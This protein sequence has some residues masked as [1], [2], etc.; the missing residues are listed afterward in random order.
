MNELA[1]KPGL[2]VVSLY[3]QVHTLAQVEARVEQSKILYPIALDGFWEFGYE[4][5][6]LPRTWIVGVDGK[7]IWA[8]RAGYKETLDKEL[9]KVKYPGLGKAEVHKSLE[10]AAKAFVEGR[11][12]EAHKLAEAVFYETDDE[13]AEADADHI[14]K[15]VDSQARDLANRAQTAEA[16]RDFELAR[17]CWAR[18]A[19][20]FK[21]H[22]DAADADKKLKELSESETA[23]QEI[24]AR[25]A[26]LALMM[27]LDV[28]FQQVDDEDAD[29]VRKFREKCVVS[30]RDFVAKQKDTGAA[31]R[32][33]VLIELI[34]ELLKQA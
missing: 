10:P 9:A 21:G 32:A 11:M 7:V 19:E 30:Y 23:A 1:A 28:E 25:R 26:L 17:R 12:A 3:A 4:A 31:E 18:L 34:E 16:M 2:H 13:K 15:R 22:D 20:R 27:D 6:V 24:A 29:A 33:Q 5:P 14:M 8:G